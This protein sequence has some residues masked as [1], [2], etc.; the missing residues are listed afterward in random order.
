MGRSGEEVVR[1]A[2]GGPNEPRSFVWR[3]WTGKGTSDVYVAIRALGGVLK[4]SLHE[5]GV[6]RYA[7]TKEF[8]EARGKKDA[9]RVIE[10]WVRPQPLYGGVTS[11]FE[12]V[13]PSA[14]LALPRQPLPESARKHLKKVTWLR[15]APE[16]HAKHIIVMYTEPGEP[17]PETDVEIL[18]NFPLPDG[19]TVSV[20]VFEFPVS[21]D[22]Q[23][24][25]EAARR[26]IAEGMRQSSMEGQAALQAE[27]ELR[28][29]LYGHNEHGT[30]FF[31][32]IAGD[33]VLDTD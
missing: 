33:P 19:R 15:P 5:S 4:V 12:I 3:I 6:W 31:I 9:D 26:A 2:V 22:N 29:Y 32:D 23:Q 30:R 8:S 7:F 18:A 21:A 10:R 16:G 25:L 28:G 14:E 20:T 1:F 27:L 11:A 24:K 17:V 13:M